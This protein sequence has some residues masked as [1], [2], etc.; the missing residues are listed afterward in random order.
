MINK[1]IDCFDNVVIIILNLKIMRKNI[2]SKMSKTLLFC[3]SIILLNSCIKETIQD[4]NVLNED[5]ITGLKLSNKDNPQEEV[6]I[7]EGSGTYNFTLTT[8][9]E[10][11]KDVVLE[12]DKLILEKELTNF[13]NSSKVDKYKL[14]PEKYY[15]L[16]VAK[17]LKGQTS[18][19]VQLEL[20]PLDDLEYEEYL[21]PLNI[22]YEGKRIIHNI[23]LKHEPEYS[24]L[25]ET[26]KK[27]MPPGTYNCPN[28]KD[29]MKMVMYVNSVGDLRNFGKFYL[30][31]SRKPV[32]DYVI[33]FA[34]AMNYDPIAKKRILA[35][36]SWIENVL[37][38]PEIYIEPLRKK[39]IKIILDIL[40]NHQG[41]GYYNFQ[42]YEEALDFARQCK[43]LADRTG[44]DGF[45][46]DEEY[47]KY[48]NRP[49][50]PRK[51]NQSVFWFMRAMKEV[52]PDKLLTLYDYGLWSL[53][54][55]SQD[56]HGKFVSDYVDFSWS[57][58]WENHASYTGIPNERYGMLS[59]EAYQRSYYFKTPEL[60]APTIRSL[61]QRNI[62]GC[63]GN[64]MFFNLT[65]DL[66]KSDTKNV[67]TA[68]SYITQIYY[69][70]DAVIEGK[71]Y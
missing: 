21:L 8:A 48:E 12:M 11:K 42:N 27:P 57:N 31:E 20:K 45:D 50:L 26:S 3:A 2:L 54:S 10:A 30:K 56:E 9:T 60:Y 37:A 28:R 71:L 13:N 7:V 23:I 39:G 49:E 29:P 25:S 32:F 5:N 59:L 53:N 47:A 40:P 34:V 65:S 18:S 68:L 69:G 52:M 14:L 64:Y 55:S 36:N 16:K 70:E 43:E 62:D 67:A 51:G 19:D 4:L 22:Y 41:V 1:S 33:P 63:Y 24:V 44:V 17:I 6:T 15:E 35:Y 61:A 38:K 66:I 58:Y 46:I